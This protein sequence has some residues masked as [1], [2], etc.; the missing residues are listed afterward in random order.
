M[1]ML[2]GVDL[3]YAN[4]VKEPC[5]WCNDSLEVTNYNNRRIRCVD[6]VGGATLTVIMSVGE[7]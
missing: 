3:V 1:S 6:K 4:S 5:Y 2:I 7:G